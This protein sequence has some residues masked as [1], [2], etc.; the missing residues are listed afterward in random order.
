[1][2]LV[3]NTIE[4]RFVPGRRGH[5]WGGNAIVREAGQIAVVIVKRPTTI[6]RKTA[7]KQLDCIVEGERGSYM[8]KRYCGW[9]YAYTQMIFDWLE[10]KKRLSYS[11]EIGFKL[12]AYVRV[13]N[14]E[15]QRKHM[16]IIVRHPTT[17]SL[18]NDRWIFV[19]I[20]NKIVY[21]LVFPAS[22]KKYTKTPDNLIPTNC[23][24]Y[25]DGRK[26]NTDLHSTVLT[27]KHRPFF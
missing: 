19:S 26:P 6:I 16:R 11:T 18:L 27:N 1:M 9:F 2:P 20:K 5:C 4:T 23:H 8:T 14:Y 22:K 10:E 21:E 13:Q 3:L 7:W 15:R 24:L 17:S 12:C 25:C